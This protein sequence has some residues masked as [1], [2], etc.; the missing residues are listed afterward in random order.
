MNI[1]FDFDGTL[2]DSHRRLYE[3][4][5]FLIPESTLSFNEYWDLKRNQID[6]KTILKKY[7]GI[8]NSQPF[9]K[10]WMKKI[11]T[12]KYLDLDK[13]HEGVTEYL[14]YL[15]NKNLSLYL[16]TDRQL[17]RGVYYQLNKFG[18]VNFFDAILITAQKYSKEDL[19]KP[20][21]STNKADYI[22]GDTGKDILTGKNLKIKSIAVSNGFLSKEILEKYRPDAI[23]NKVT[24]FH[25]E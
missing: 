19:I 23:Y 5:Q 13:P 7:F 3:L 9:E 24:D 17:P 21:I 25:P 11:E 6:H 8:N 2:I 16:I 18:W 1:F 14:I 15:K 10:E 4:F 12:K 20:L 22:V